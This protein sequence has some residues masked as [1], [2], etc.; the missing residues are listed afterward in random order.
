[1]LNSFLRINGKSIIKRS[2]P[3]R[4]I[5][6][7]DL[8][9]NPWSSLFPPSAGSR[10]GVGNASVLHNLVVAAAPF[11]AL[12][13]GSKMVSDWIIDLPFSS[14]PVTTRRTLPILRFSL[15]IIKIVLL[16]CSRNF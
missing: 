12:L 15:N 16:Y 3:E 7:G 6:L 13:D 14:K 9:P 5:P 4:A 10:I 11:G 1:M 8:I 2:R